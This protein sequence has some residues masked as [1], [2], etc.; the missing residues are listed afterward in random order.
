MTKGKQFVVLPGTNDVTIDGFHV[1][2]L[3]WIDRD[4]VENGKSC[5]SR[6]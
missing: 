4:K 3:I 1:I 6:L 5:P 2:S